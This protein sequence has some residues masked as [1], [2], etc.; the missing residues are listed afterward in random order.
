M[1]TTVNNVAATLGRALLLGGTGLVVGLAA[2]LLT[3]TRRQQ[4]IAA[5]SGI[6]VLVA[7]FVWANT[8]ESLAGAAVTVVVAMNGVGFVVGLL[9]VALTRKRREH[10]SP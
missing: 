5:V 6:A 2:G 4:L 3:R 10:L 1:P 9:G 7:L 8:L